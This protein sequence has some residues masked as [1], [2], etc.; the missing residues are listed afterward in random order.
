M[1][2][3]LWYSVGFI[4]LGTGKRSIAV[5]SSRAPPPNKIR[6]LHAGEGRG[7]KRNVSLLFFLSCGTARGQRGRGRQ[8]ENK[9]RCTPP[10]K[11]KA[12]LPLPRYKKKLY[13][14]RRTARLDSHS[15]RTVLIGV[16]P[17]HTPRGSLGSS[18]PTKSF[19]LSSSRQKSLM[20]AR[21]R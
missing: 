8:N 1:V 13:T 7:G 6:L 10:R 18:V 14:W 4:N 11:P 15:L 19:A 9:S 17:R 20:L 21:W 5:Q 16:C 2:L 12:L 3:P